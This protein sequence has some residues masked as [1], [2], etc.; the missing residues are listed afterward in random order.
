[1]GSIGAIFYYNQSHYITYLT[2]KIVQATAWFILG[3]AAC[4]LF[5][6][7]SSL[8]DHEIIAF[9]T[10]VII[11]G[12]IQR[13]NMI[14]DLD[15]SWI[16]FIG[17]ISYGIYVIHPLIIFLTLQTIGSFATSA[18]LNYFFIYVIICSATILTSYLS[19]EYFEKRFLGLKDR[20]AKIKS[21]A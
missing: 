15:R 3:L 19:Y 5:H 1:M 9:V 6:I 4:N 17:K 8:I 7:S 14:I 21:R 2:T 16:N 18:I 12:Q 11:F 13:T 20:F 10:I